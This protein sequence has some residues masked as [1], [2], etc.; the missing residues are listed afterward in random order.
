MSLSYKDI[1]TD[2]QWRS[3]TGLSEQ[4]FTF[5]AAQLGKVYQERY[6]VSLQE[7][8]RNVKQQFIFTTYEEMLF[9]VLFILKNTLTWDNAGLIFGIS[10]GDAHLNLTR[11][12]P[13]LQTA[14]ERLSC[15]PVRDL[16]DWQKLRPEFSRQLVLLMDGSE[17][18]VQRP[19]DEQQQEQAFSGKKRHTRKLLL[20]STTDRRILYV[21]KLYNGSVHDKKMADQEIKDQSAVF[22]SKELRVDSG[23][24]GIG[25][26]LKDCKV[27]IP[28]KKKKNNNLPSSRKKLT[29]KKARIESALNM[30]LVA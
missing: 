1:R 15:L 25:K 6:G 5:L 3:A 18:A 9:F 24:L 29:K 2:R 30:P 7:K 16:K 26:T 13:L 4:K 19:V 12:F 14:L 21:S 11:F 20:L 8:M 28:E 27:E 22:E 10:G 23:F 17:V